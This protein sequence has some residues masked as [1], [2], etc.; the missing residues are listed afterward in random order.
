MGRLVQ[1]GE[2]SREGGGVAEGAGRE[3]ELD[4]ADGDGVSGRGREE[5]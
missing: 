1:E 4:W 3:G 5:Q 2:G